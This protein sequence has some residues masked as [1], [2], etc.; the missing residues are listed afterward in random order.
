MQQRGKVLVSKYESS[1]SSS[2][3]VIKLSN[4]L[5][6]IMTPLFKLLHVYI[7]FEKS[8]RLNMNETTK[9]YTSLICSSTRVYIKTFI[10]KWGYGKKNFFL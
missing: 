4:L 6:Q 9:K 8:K 3:F 2:L 7:Y 10:E 1:L 5:T